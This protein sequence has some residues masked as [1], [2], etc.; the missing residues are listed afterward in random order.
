MSVLARISATQVAILGV[1]VCLTARQGWAQSSAPAYVHDCRSCT[2][3]PGGK[4]APYAFTFDLAREDGARRVQAIEVKHGTRP[5]QKLSVSDME[6][7]GEKE[8]FFFGGEDINF[9][10]FL[11][12]ELIVSKGVANSYA[13]YWLF[14]PK[15][16]KYDHL[17]T[18]PIF[19]VDAKKRRLFTYERGGTAGLIHTAKEYAFVKGKLTLVREEKQDATSDPNRFRKVI[20]RLS[21]GA[22]RT[23]KTE[24]VRAPK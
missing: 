20:R 9:D 15:S 17:G 4:V 2:F 11:D 13:A 21:R 6:P 24:T 14:N 22:L 5:A 3:S 23:V 1:A 16:G 7:I 10:G 18:Y 12:L 19:R 8:D